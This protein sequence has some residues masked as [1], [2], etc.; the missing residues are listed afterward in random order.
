MKRTYPI[1]LLISIVLCTSEFVFLLKGFKDG[2]V[3]YIVFGILATIAL[4]L[5]NA[6]GADNKD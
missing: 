6:C 4:G 5:N 3:I 2:N 1:H